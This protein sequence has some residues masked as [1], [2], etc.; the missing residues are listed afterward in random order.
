MKICVCIPTYNRADLIDNAILSLVKQA[1]A[2]LDIHVFDDAST[3]NTK[4]VVEKYKDKKVFYHSNEKNV[5]YVENV[6]NCLRMSNSYDWIGIL[7][8]DDIHMADSIRIAKKYI[9]KYPQAGLIFSYVHI[10]DVG[11]H[12][13]KKVSSEEKC[14]KASKETSFFF[15]NPLPCSS[16]F[17]NSRAIFTVG[18]LSNDFPYSA[19]EEY[20]TRISKDFDIV[21]TGE[22]MACYRVHSGH[23]KIETWIKPDF[24]KTFKRMRFTMAAHAFSNKLEGESEAR[25]SIARTLFFKAPILMVEGYYG[26]YL[27]FL[28]EAFAC[29]KRLFLKPKNIA[30]L[31]IQMIPFYNY[32]FYK[33]RIM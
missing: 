23:Y 13:K 2:D 1:D 4:A 14:Y 26:A 33:K 16:I 17:Y 11:G 9:G 31:L 8:N 28:R 22:V 32:Y 15:Q 24:L 18:L 6:N 19:D 3:D 20:T 29:D 30:H 10:I 27:S 25:K 5:G 12:Y 7:H 21:Q